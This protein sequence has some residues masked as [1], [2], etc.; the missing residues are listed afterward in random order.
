MDR[1][2]I[3]K[4]VE[5]GAP[6]YH[7]EN[8]YKYTDKK[9]NV[10]EIPRVSE[11]TFHTLDGLIYALKAEYK[12][13]NGPLLI[14]VNDEESVTVYSAIQS[15]DRKREIPYRVSAELVEIPFDRKLDYETMM[16][17]L[18]SKFVETD[19]L[20]EVVKLLGTI[21]EENSMT[22]SDDG[23]TQNVVVRTGIVAK[24]NAAVKPIVRLKPYR[25]FIEVDQPESEFLLR[26]SEGGRVALYEADG[27][28]WKIKA[29]RNVADYLKDKLSDLIEKGEAIVVE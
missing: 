7:E 4:I 29:R 11:L 19:E 15:A 24:G 9:L 6:N 8:G 17:T 12:N 28:A 26:L 1:T 16:I 22:A 14:D 5:L 3:E 27:G 23:F 18:R 2:A 13:F 21:V 25:T 10:I 20:L